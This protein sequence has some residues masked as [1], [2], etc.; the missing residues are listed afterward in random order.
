M[1]HLRRKTLQVAG[2]AAAALLS[3]LPLGCED[4]NE[5][6][7]NPPAGLGTLYVDNHTGDDLHVFID[8]EEKHKAGDY[9]KRYYD[10]EPGVRRVVLAEEDGDRSFRDDVDVLEG[11][12]TIIEVSHEPGDFDHYDVAVFFDD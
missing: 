10:L 4:T 12:R 6:D 1:K 3:L 9:D 2:V 8:G 11:H 5:Y 7:H